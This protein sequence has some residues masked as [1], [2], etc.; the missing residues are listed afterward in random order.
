MH[1]FNIIN[2]FKKFNLFTIYSICDP[3]LCCSHAPILSIMT[4]PASALHQL[5]KI[6][7]SVLVS[8]HSSYAFPPSKA[9][10][11]FN[12]ILGTLGKCTK[13]NN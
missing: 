10:Q 1:Y 9:F 4:T 11:P 3:N 7:K 2:I 5:I 12:P 13:S 6:N 8:E